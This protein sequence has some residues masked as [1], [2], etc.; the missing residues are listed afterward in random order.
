M[1]HPKT[2]CMESITPSMP[3]SIA[4]DFAIVLNFPGGS[5]RTK[6]TAMDTLAHLEDGVSK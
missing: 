5:S 2:L 4:T 3:K 1:L 6:V